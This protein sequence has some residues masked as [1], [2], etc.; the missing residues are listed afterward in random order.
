VLRYAHAP[1]QQVCPTL[2]AFPQAPQL[3]MLLRSVQTLLQQP[4]A[5]AEQQTP[6]QQVPVQQVRLS[7]VKPHSMLT[8]G[9]SRHFAL[10]TR[11]PRPL[12]NLEQNM[13]QAALESA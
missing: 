9:H 5:V 3:L 1:L 8:L 6:L 7:T 11:I 4:C 2:Q 13:L 12:L 10:H